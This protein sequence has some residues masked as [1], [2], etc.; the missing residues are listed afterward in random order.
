ML[1]IIKVE[2]EFYVRARSSLADSQTRALV[3]GDL[4]AVFDRH[5]D[6][7]P[8]GFGEHGLFYREARHLSGLL[9]CLQGERLLLLGSAVRE[10]NAVLAV[11]LTNPHLQ[12]PNGGWLPYGSVHIYRTKFLN[13]NTCYE[14]IRVRNYGLGFVSFELLVQFAADFTDIFEI[15]GYRRSHRGKFSPPEIHKRSVTFTYHGLDDITRTTTLRSSLEPAKVTDSE[16]RF[17]LDLQPGAEKELVLLVSC[18]AGAK[19]PVLSYT[20]ASNARDHR[21]NGIDSVEIDTSNEQFNEWLNRS[22]ADLRTMITETSEGPYPYGGVP[23]FA[24]PF[25]RDGLITA[26]ECLWLDPALAKGVLKYLAVTQATENNPVQ[27]AEPGKI[28]HETRKSELAQTGEVPFGRY[29]GSADATPLFL[30]L[31]AAYFE[32]T[33]DRAFLETIWPNI[34]LALQWIEKFGDRDGDGFV[35][36]G[37]RSGKG[38]V[39][40]GWKDSQDSVFHADGSLAEPPI[41]ICELQAYVYAAKIGISEVAAALGYQEQARKL[42]EEAK[43]LRER[44]QEAFWS[45][46][47]GLYVLALDKDK[48]QCRVASSNAG[49]CLYTGIATKERA[50][51]IM[52]RLRD[53][54][55]FSGFGVRTIASTEKRYSPMAYHNGSV[56]P[57]DNALIA[58]GCTKS[59]HKDLAC[60]I[61]NGLLDSSIFLDLHRLPELF[62]GFPRRRGRGPTLYPVACPLQAWA[63]G[64]AFL[65]LQACLGLSIRASESKV[66]FHYPALPE[67]IRQVWIKNLRVGNGSVDLELRRHQK[68]VSGNISRRDGNVQI[69]TF[70]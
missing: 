59:E 7:Q 48:K 51:T 66:Y 52:E 22:R 26:L 37:R 2:N 9:L 33:A 24:T 44:F 53:K 60:E 36:Y 29:Y 20:E 5:G 1:D 38:L 41:A 70:K 3:H 61:L 54:A 49:H 46:E 65:V 40:Q 17:R 69:V 68:A 62:C 23:W 12:L 6:L 47:L 25:G 32:R 64:A 67:S 18:D 58:F 42:V 63:A 34:E 31:A 50:R 8:I 19:V 39:H 21:E 4:F 28:L 15:R 45:E 16:M 35:E 11:D 13:W 14:R 56:W 27:D 55:F 43:A 10:D 30:Y 57:H